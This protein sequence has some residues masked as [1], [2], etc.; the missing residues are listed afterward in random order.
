LRTYF[1]NSH[2]VTR[3]DDRHVLSCIIFITCKD[4]R[5]RDAPWKYGYHKT[6]SIDATYFKAHRTASGLT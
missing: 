5:W 4:L 2:D 6:I 3:V 1:P